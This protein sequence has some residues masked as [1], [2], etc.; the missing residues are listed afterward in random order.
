MSANAAGLTLPQPRLWLRF[1]SFARGPAENEVEALVLQPP[2]LIDLLAPARWMPT[3][4]ADPEL[5][6]VLGVIQT[7]LSETRRL[8]AAPK[9][10]ATL[11]NAATVRELT[12]LVQQGPAA[13]AIDSAWAQPPARRRRLC[14]IAARVRAGPRRRAMARV[15]RAFRSG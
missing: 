11:R 5:R 2:S 7:H 9:A 6:K 13:L 3:R 12:S 8:L 1:P 4:H 14:R 10:R 15:E